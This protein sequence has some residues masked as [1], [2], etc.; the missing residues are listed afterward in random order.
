MEST[1][2]LAY[3]L[4]TT[5]VCVL[6]VPFLIACSQPFFAMRRLQQWWGDDVLFHARGVRERRVALTVDDAPSDDCPLLLDALRRHGCRATFFVISGHARRSACGSASLTRM[7][8]EGHEIANHGD[9]DHKAVL[10]SE[11][12][13]LD[14]FHDC[15]RT[16]RTCWDQAAREQE[17]EEHSTNHHHHHHRP[18]T[19]T[20][21]RAAAEDSNAEN[22]NA[23]P[24]NYYRP[25]GG[26]FTRRMVRHLKNV[27][28]SVRGSYR[29][30]LGSV[31]PYDAGP[32]LFRLGKHRKV[33]WVL[34]RVRPGAIVVMH[35]RD[36]T[37]E[38]LDELLPR[39]KKE[40]EV[41]TLSELLLSE[42]RE[43]QER[44][45]YE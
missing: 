44:A 8:R 31:Y 33:R 15:E 2:A 25:G 9:E 18:L 17:G 39:L 19:T 4:W 35:D 6:V 23:R 34:D 30:V 21:D 29:L 43:N 14:S 40:Y 20:N 38:M 27:P 1:T 36:Y 13:F 7:L 5:V 37:P 16:L 41:G 32:A 3:A 12:A 10:L 24:N 22:V 45:R 26:F 42:Q 28:N 11:T